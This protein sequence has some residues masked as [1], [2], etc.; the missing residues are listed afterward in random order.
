MKIKK[1]LSASLA[2]LMV[3]SAA[4]IPAFAAEDAKD[5]VPD[6]FPTVDYVDEMLKN[7]D[8]QTDENGIPMVI[9]PGPM[10]NAAGA[11]AGYSLTVNGDDRAEIPVMVPLRTV[12]EALGFTVTWN[13]D[14]TV[15]L[16]SGAM[17]MELTIGEDCYQAVTSI[18]DAVGTTG[19]LSLGVAPFV[20][21]GVTYVPLQAFDIL[22]GNNAVAL[23]NGKITVQVQEP[24]GVRPPS[25]FIPC[26]TMAEA[27]DL[28]G[29]GLTAPKGADIVEG[30]DSYM[31][32]LIYGEEDETMRIRKAADEGDIS[33]DYTNYDQV[34]T[35]NS[36]T[37]K[38]AGDVYSLA[39]WEKDGYAYSVSVAAGLSQADL[40]ALAASVR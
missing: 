10:D 31:I 24:E 22:L 17:H 16:D 13:G 38:G 36:V 30:W 32:Q 28:A 11:K 33:G 12:A 21:N 9:A 39:I 29:F 40:L 35:V 3:M 14:G 19:P 15:T 7:L 34:K 20:V 5:A 23:E 1:T 6:D 27:E 25:P 8:G 2:A 37:I 4:A 26:A 18:E